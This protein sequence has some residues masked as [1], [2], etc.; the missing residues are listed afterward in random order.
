MAWDLFG[1]VLV[2][3]FPQDIVDYFAP[4][5]KF[6]G[7]RESQLQTRVDGPTQTR[8]LRMDTALETD[9]HGKR[10]LLDHELQ[11]TKDGLIGERLLDYSREYRRLY[12]LPVRSAVTYFQE[13]SDPPLSPM[14]DVFPCDPLPEGN[15]SVRFTYSSLI[16]PQKTVEE[17]R[18]LN[19]DIFTTYMLLAKD[20]GTPAILDEVVDRLQRRDN[21]SNGARKDQY[22]T[23]ITV[24]LYYAGRVFKSEEDLAYL[25]RKGEMLHNTLEDNQFYKTMLGKSYEK[26]KEEGRVEGWE[27]GRE[28]GRVE[29]RVEQVHQ[30]IEAMTQARFPDLLAFV[31][32]QI[33]SLT[34]LNRLQEILI[35]IGTAGTEDEIKAAFSVD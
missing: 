22:Q 33:S 12:K 28:E 20:G 30:N 4:G 29:G 26:T 34:D 8:E 10:G 23:A 6:V 32:N 17:L 1:K 13:V 15:E 16:L 3:A 14:I 7:F 5:A 9:Y 19:L 21:E 31:K 11:S 2:K 35:T 27:E 18:G 25:E 24:A